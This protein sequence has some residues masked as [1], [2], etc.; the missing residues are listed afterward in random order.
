MAFASIG[1]L[2]TGSS[3]SNNQSSMTLTT[4]T[5]AGVPGNLAVWILAMDN[6]QTTDGDEVAVT[7]VTDS[8][9]NRWTK[10]LEFTNGQGSAQAGH[11]CSMWY[12]VLLNA[13]PI[14]ATLTATLSNNTSRDVSTSS[15]WLFSIATNTVAIEATNTLANDA[16]DPGSLTA[17]TANIECL[18]IRG[19]GAE[20][21]SATALTNTASWTLFSSTQ[22][23]SPTA[24]GS[25]I[26]GEFIISTTT[27]AASDPTF[28]SADMAS[29][30]VAFKESTLSPKTLSSLGVG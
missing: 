12:S 8:A 19:I 23:G 10:A 3:G 11:L 18:R 30:Y 24:A 14:G 1:T 13:L 25:A 17:T 6:N 20:T 4:V 29:I 27:S 15:A 21:N 5:N 22:V 2:G 9:G 7:G 28:V 26:R 16:A